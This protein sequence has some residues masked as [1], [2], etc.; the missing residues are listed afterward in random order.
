MTETI[1]TQQEWLRYSRHIQ[2]PNFGAAGQTKLKQSHV[3]IVGMGGLGAPV[4]LYLAAAG[5]GKFT[6][7]DGDTVD[8]TNLQR[9]VIFN[10]NDVGH[11]KA[12]QAKHHMLALNP[13]IHI[14]AIPD[15]FQ[16]KH[17]ALIDQNTSLVLDCT[18]NFNT[19]YLINDVCVRQKVAWLYASIHQYSGQCALFTPGHACFRCLFPAPPESAPDCN[20]AGVIGVL[21]GLLGLFEANEAIKYLSD[22]P[23]ELENRLL[24]FDAL[25]LSVQKI[26]LAID[27]QCF[28]Q[29]GEKGKFSSPQMC[30]EVQQ[31]SISV[32]DFNL[33]RE[34]ANTTVIDVR[35][36]AE[37]LGFNIGGQHIP[38]QEILT[39][40]DS[41][42]HWEKNRQYICYCQ[43]GSRSEQAAQHLQACGLQAVSLD[44]GLLAWL[45][46]AS[47]TQMLHP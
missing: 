13:H 8:E 41:N 40:T 37:R 23:L 16:P 35:T 11:A 32:L 14:D 9:Q 3:V 47:K 7:F 26:Q 6:I 20:T 36:E 19:R 27:P 10:Q 25:K 39:L 42:N 15:F 1:F 46:H 17:E 38:L 22:L 45:K 24:L 28:C 30:A 31:Q 12:L 4:A 21:P 44:G 18:D 5:V 34:R 29:T 2:L 43:S 33:H